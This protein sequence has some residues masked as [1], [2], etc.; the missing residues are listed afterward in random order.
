M[1][2]ERA[3][4]G[5]GDRERSAYRG[6]ILSAEARAGGRMGSNHRKRPPQPS[7]RCRLCTQ[8]PR[9][10]CRGARCREQSWSPQNMPL[11][12]EDYFRMNIFKKH[13]RNSDRSY[14]LYESFT[15]IRGVSI[16]Y[17]PSST[18]KQK[19]PSSLETIDA[20]GKDQEMHILALVHCTLPEDL[21]Q[22]ASWPQHLLLPFAGNGI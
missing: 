20:K 15:S 10:E 16:Q 1:G 21:P 2:T 14:P 22:P 6:G 3:G 11:W 18:S 12:H 19:M 13:R 7:G 9:V 8:R 5:W 4:D 17:L